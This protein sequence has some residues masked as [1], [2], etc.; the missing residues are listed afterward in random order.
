MS[1]RVHG[2]S[3]ARG[4]MVDFAVNVW[5][6]TRPASL[7]AALAG[8]LDRS[9]RYPDEREARNALAM[10]HGRSSD[11][12]LLTDGACEAFWLIA[13]AFRPTTAAL[14]TRA[15]PSRRRLGAPSAATSARVS[16]AESGPGR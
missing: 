13:H 2:D 1:L 15:S 9:E 3:F 5:P 7:E 12:V 10:R 16:R 8:A 4:D 14:S 11:E 6:A